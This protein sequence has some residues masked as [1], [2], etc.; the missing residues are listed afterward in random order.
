MDSPETLPR[1]RPR[2][3]KSVHSSA[4]GEDSDHDGCESSGEASDD[5]YVPPTLNSRKRTR[6]SAASPTA[7]PSSSSTAPNHPNKRARMAPPSRNKHAEIQSVE[8]PDDD[9]DLVCHVCSWVQKNG[10]LPDFKR[11]L[12]THQR[13]FEKDA[14]TGWWCK[15]V[16]L[17]EAADYGLYADAPTYKFLGEERVGG[18]M[19]TFSR[20]DALK[21]HLDNTN[22]SCVGRPSAAT[23]Q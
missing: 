12:K 17:S 19:K 22:V 11:H 8:S 5:E 3:R 10:R 23:Q 13:A 1:F 6:R 21:R 14:Q 15:G 16:L 2:R 9:N 18:C 4:S 7:S 20:A